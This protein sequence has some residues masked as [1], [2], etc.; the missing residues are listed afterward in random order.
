L[1]FLFRRFCI[2]LAG[3]NLSQKKMSGI[4]IGVLFE[5]ALVDPTGVGQIVFV[6]VD[7]AKK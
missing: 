3:I 5:Q 6:H 1:E 7:A 4:G 2:T